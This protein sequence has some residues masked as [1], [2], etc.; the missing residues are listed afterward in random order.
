[1]LASS[2][3]FLV[4][5]SAALLA[6]CG[7]LSEFREPPAEKP[8]ASAAPEAGVGN[9]GPQSQ[10]PPEDQSPQRFTWDPKRRIAV[11]E[12]GRENT[13]DAAD[14]SP[15]SEG[16]QPDDR[17][18]APSP[19]SPLPKDE[20]VRLVETVADTPESRKLVEA[21]LEAVGDRP[22]RAFAL[23]EGDTLKDRKMLVNLLR[24]YVQLELG[25][26]EKAIA[27]LDEAFRELRSQMPL[28]INAPDFCRKV[29][30]FGK[31]EPFSHRVFR[32]AEQV[33]LYFEPQYFTCRQAG[34]GYTISL[35]V[36]YSIIDS[37][38]KQVWQKEQS[39]DHGTTRYLYDLFLTQ[40]IQMPS[41]AE[42][43]YKIKI[44]AQDRLSEDQHRAE[45]EMKFEIR[46]L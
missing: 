20:L 19:G 12:P 33:I 34:D 38:G 40:F 13:G 7:F 18:R 43:N 41:L 2:R 16:T 42:G 35:N 30:S 21:M 22:D 10:S 24:A 11:P 39:V 44:E 27:A 1:M 4:A 6:G 45:A 14:S 15:G 28:K 23:L 25:D 36:R 32:P 8:G 29:Q 26:T 17:S 37:A 31:Y 3:L 9:P 5:A 46:N